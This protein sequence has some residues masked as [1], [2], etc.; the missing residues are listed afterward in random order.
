[1]AKLKSIRRQVTGKDLAFNIVLYAICI[2]ILL[3]DVY[4]RQAHGTAG[5]R[6]TEWMI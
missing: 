6:K 5:I 3:I 4:K 1:M 2:I